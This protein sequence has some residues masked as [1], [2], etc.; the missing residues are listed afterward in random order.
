GFNLPLIDVTD[1]LVYFPI[2]VVSEAWL[3]SPLFMLSS[4]VI[5]E[6]L[7][8]DCLEASE[9]MGALRRHMLTMVYLP[10]ILR[11]RV[12]A[13]LVA[14]KSVDF[15]RSFEV[16]FAWSF[17]VRESQLGAPTDTLS[18]MLFKL[19][20][21]AP[22]ESTI[23]IPYISAVSTALMTASLITSLLVFRQVSRMWW[24]RVI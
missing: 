23:P 4:I 1:P 16:P 5:L 17:W 24:R 3:W 12:T 19:L 11:S 21:S 6:G 7:P 20:T 2:M 10:A 22:A 13:M 9:L 18:L 14:L 8:K 15:F